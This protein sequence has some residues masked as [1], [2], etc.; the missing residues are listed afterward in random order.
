M[1]GSDMIHVA[2]GSE[3]FRLIRTY[4]YGKQSKYLATEIGT[5]I[6]EKSVYIREH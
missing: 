6:L 5:S 1:N 2:V 3:L 4:I